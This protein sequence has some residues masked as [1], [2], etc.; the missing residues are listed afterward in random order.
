MACKEILFSDHAITQMFKR[1]I[2]LKE[3]NHGMCIM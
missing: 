2:S 3:I 1:S